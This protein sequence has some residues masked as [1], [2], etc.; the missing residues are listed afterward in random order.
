M[1]ENVKYQLFEKSP[2]ESLPSLQTQPQSQSQSQNEIEYHIKL[3][4]ESVTKYVN[5]YHPKLFILTPCFGSVCYADY[6]ASLLD[7][8]ELFRKFNIPI[9]VQFCKND[10]LVSRARNN[11]IAKA[12]YNKEIT[13]VMF[14]DNDIGWDPYSILKL[15]ISDKPIIAGIYPLK[16]Y[17]WN[18]LVKDPLNPYN[19]NV[20]Q[21]WIDK[22]NASQLNGYVNDED[23]VQFNLLNYNV[24]YLSSNV[25]IENNLTKVRHAATGFMMI[26]RNVIEKMFKAF[27]STKYTDDVGF[28]KPEENE[29]AYALFDCGVENNHYYSEDWLFCHRWQKMGG[30]VWIDVSINLSHT[31]IEVY[32]GCYMTNLM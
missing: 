2:F 15:L 9:G 19:S 14:I 21:S 6:T 29:Y 13:H 11:L 31:G 20:I 32:K 25:E 22:K 16:N 17:N 23:I 10:S 18:K 8:L 27:P 28:L 7:T 5:Q 4:E 24:N 26:Q 3:F 1:S 12:L 30:D